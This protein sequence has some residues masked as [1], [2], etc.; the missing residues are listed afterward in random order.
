MILLEAKVVDAT[1][2]Q[3]ARPINAKRGRTVYISVSE[4]EEGDGDRQQW[5]AASLQKLQAAYGDAE[6]DYS[7]AMVKEPNTDYRA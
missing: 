3:L 2:L 1:H 7:A 4:T 6:P 5:H